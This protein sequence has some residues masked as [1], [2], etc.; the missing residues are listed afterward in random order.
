MHVRTVKLAL[1]LLFVVCVGSTLP[2]WAQS[3]D[4]GTVVGLV[5]D[6]TGAV[7]VG[8][9]VTL[10][11]TSTSTSQTAVTNDTGRYTFVNVKPGFYNISITKT[12]FSTTKTER[13]EVKVG[14]TLT[15]DLALQVGGANVVVEVT[16][17]G[18]ELQT[19]DATV[20]QTITGDALD[21][22]PGLGRDVS[23]F[24]TLQPGVA[25]DGSVAG[26]N[27][28]Q[29]SFQ[30]DGGNNSSDMDGTQNTY[31][32]SFAGDPTGGLVNNEVT[33]TSPGG[34]PGGGG[35][36]GVMPTPADSIEEFRVATNNQTAD[37]NSSAGA[38]VRL[39]TK[40]GT[41]QWHGT[42]YEYYLDNNWSANSWDNN[43]HAG[44]AVVPPDPKIPIPSYHYNR[45]GGSIGGPLFPK[46]FLGGKTFFFANYEGFRWP[47]SATIIRAT[48]S[49]DMQLGLI[50][51]VNT[52]IQYNLNPYSVTNT[53]GN[54]VA[55]N[56][57]CSSDLTD[58]PSGVCDPQGIGISQT[59]QTMWQ[60]MPKSNSS[61]CLGLVRCDGVNVQ[62][63]TANYAIKWRDD[64]AVARLDH[65]FGAKWRFYTTYRYYHQARD[66][67]NQIDIAGGT[68]VST[69]ARPSVPWYGTASL[70]TNITNN[71]T[72]DFH[73]SF[74]RNWWARSSLGDPVQVA[75]LGGALEPMGEDS[76]N[77]LAPI[78]LDTQDVR[79]RF[80]DGKDHMFRD[81]VSWVK[82]T[83]F[84][85]F[86]GLYQHNW[87]YHQRTDNGG[88]INYQPV[89]W[90]GRAVTGLN[91]MNMA[92]FEPTGVN[93]RWVRDYGIVLGAPAVDQI[94]YT[95]TGA[96]LNLNP[97]NTP[98]FDQS[99][100][101]FYNL[102][103][104]DSW[105]MTPSLTLSYGLGWALEMPPK[106]AQGKQIAFVDNNDKIIDTAAYLKS[107]ESAALAGQ[108]FNPNLGFALI[109]NVAGHPSNFYNPFY[110]SFS[111][112]IAVAWNP[113]FD[114]D[115]LGGKIF[116]H[117]NT[118]LRG[119]YSILYGR[120]N[121]VG[122]VLLPLL[123]TGL[124]QAVQCISPTNTG[125]CQGNV[126]STPGT[127]FRI[128]PPSQNAACGGLVAPLPAASPTLPQPDYP[129]IN[130]IAAGAG[131]AT[132]INLRPSMNQQ[133][134]FTI[135]RQLNQKMSVELGYIGRHITHEFQPVNVTAI[136][137]MMTLGGQRFDK[138]YGQMVMQYCGGNA[139]LAGGNCAGT[140]SA[141]TAQPFFET[142]LAGT[143]YCT[144]FANCTQAVA[145]RE[146]NTGTG[147]IGSASVWS[148]WNDL[149][150]GGA[151]CNSSG[152]QVFVLGG[153]GPCG[154]NFAR[155]TQASP[156][157]CVQG[158]EIGCGGQLTSGVGENT[159]LGYGNYNALFVSYKMSTWHGLTMQSNFTWSKS[160]GTGSLVQATSQ[161][162]AN[163]P[164]D[165][166]RGY[167]YQPWD[168]K[169]MFNVWFTYTPP[170]Y[171]GQH[172]L[173]GHILGGWTF[174]PILDIGSGIPYGIGPIG[175]GSSVYTGGQEFG[176]TDGGNIGSY[177][178]AV[179]ICGNQ[180]INSSRH[181]NFDASTAGTAG[182]P[183]LFANPGA[184]YNCFR[185][186]ILGIDNGHN[187]G[188]GN[189]RGMPFWNVDFS[190]KKNLAIT[191]RFGAEFGAVFTNVF[192]HVQL[193]DPG[194]PFL[195]DTGD[196]GSLVGVAGGFQVNNGR[197]IE[198]D[199]RLKF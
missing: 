150:G 70:S 170:V 27:Q 158:N 192:N 16:A 73:Y 3:T 108:V 28:D 99:T 98:A 104:N 88:G 25:P 143:G 141:V 148:L 23:T 5:R 38:Q 86:G 40:R 111:P 198:I 175:F 22:L 77:V 133:Y 146:G 54:L 180:G 47:N 166:G 26:G 75:G 55:A 91:G 107:R 11:D 6:S 7:V 52:G 37:F 45:F 131:S 191:E 19:M 172:G 173:A 126:G 4:T 57:G 113:Q 167:G 128:C 144:G 18:N 14:T 171:Q 106:E 136:P 196:F 94:A 163:D 48:P 74:L 121:G 71:L 145:S 122:L 82:G 165:L 69:A 120:L 66:V 89:Y 197:K 96:A 159:S 93:S 44:N 15:V 90:L 100:I 186:P 114:A 12:G 8:A 34:S 153:T 36:T 60:S 134:D 20:G 190:V 72:N 64:F 13:Q 29:N 80:W 32:A 156:L 67:N 193:Y 2:A 62:A 149:D 95:R 79:T 181:D 33:G 124:I 49:P 68:P 123:G 194:L 160:L 97:P 155:S 42:A 43:H 142:A 130:A 189:Y 81:D 151:P 179:N 30:L 127:S 21:S 61:S 101:P 116:G 65:D 147:N 102:Y 176:A 39:V 115:S 152:Q 103:V 138:A 118:V 9:K 195:G 87:N 183:N 58:F 174:A 137:Y 112:R 84:F 199:F 162:T 168:R 187:G 92:G 132:D 164:F 169:F 140:L 83:H 139:G 76:K 117:N 110:K 184:V 154:F 59:V 182:T 161:Y 1:F 10:T 63:F 185:N 188:I 24:V 109:G 35:P 50:T 157:N 17:T 46:E 85:T 125:G 41:N 119:G 135:Q 31:T 177:S 78:N 105:R 129:G 178:N 53:A 51:D 56:A